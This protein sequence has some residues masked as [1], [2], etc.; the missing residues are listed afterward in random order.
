[1]TRR[2][3]SRSR[4][5]YSSSSSG[6]SS[7]HV[8]PSVPS[9]PESDFRRWTSRDEENLE[10]MRARLRELQMGST[11]GGPA[12]LPS[13]SH[14]SSGGGSYRSGRSRPSYT[15]DSSGYAGTSIYTP[16]RSSY[17]TRDYEYDTAD[18][19]SRSSGS[20]SG[21]V[22]YSN[23]GSG[24]SR[25]SGRAPDASGGFWTTTRIE[26]YNAYPSRSGRGRQSSSSSQSSRDPPMYSS[27]DSSSYGDYVPSYRSSA[28][29]R[30]SSFS[31]PPGLHSSLSA[32]GSRYLG[33]YSGGPSGSPSG[34]PGAYTANISRPRIVVAEE[35]DDV[36][37]RYYARPGTPGEWSPTPTQRRRYPSPT[38]SISPDVYSDSSSSD[39]W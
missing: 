38:R 8:P 14:S 10:A 20:S 5:E 32:S 26:R 6:S 23:Y 15:D 17:D 36:S 21:T 11:L 13:W 24:S 39:S 27:R 34:N 37:E 12:G 19:R 33:S 35:P 18:E 31:A 16:S 25:S 30:A 22:R 28:R 9:P 4:Y 3:R 29:S 7:R 2:H 1:M